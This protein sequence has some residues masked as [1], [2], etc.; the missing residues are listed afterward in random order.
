[1]SQ[2]LMSFIKPYRVHFGSDRSG[3]AEGGG[4]AVDVDKGERMHVGDEFRGEFLPGFGL[5]G[6]FRVVEFLAAGAGDD[7]NDAIGFCIGFSIEG[8][9][10]APV[11][12][13]DATA[14]GLIVPSASQ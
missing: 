2:N 12:V 9:I 10:Q 14:D 11:P 8:S 1:M 3:V 5:V 6:L 4:V 7:I 13:D